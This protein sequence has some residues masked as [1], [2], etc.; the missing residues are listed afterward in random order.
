MKQSQRMINAL[1]R[2]QRPFANMKIF[3]INERVICFEP[4]ASEYGRNDG[5]FARYQWSNWDGGFPT[6]HMEHILEFGVTQDQVYRHIDNIRVRAS[7]VVAW[8]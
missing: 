6:Q 8:P 2:S 1:A 5:F 7:M 4:L 3:K